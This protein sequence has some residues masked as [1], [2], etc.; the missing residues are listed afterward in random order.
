MKCYRKN[1]SD[2][3]LGARR[4]AGVRPS[5]KCYRKNGSDNTD[6]PLTIEKVTPQ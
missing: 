3:R 2:G 1:G 5:M 4:A 6:D